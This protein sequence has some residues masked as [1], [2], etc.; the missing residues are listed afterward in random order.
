MPFSFTVVHLDLQNEIH[1][2]HEYN[3]YKG[4]EGYLKFLKKFLEDF[5]YDLQILMD[6]LSNDEITKKLKLMQEE[7]IIFDDPNHSFRLAIYCRTI[8]KSPKLSN[9]LNSADLIPIYKRNFVGA[10]NKNSF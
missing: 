1:K 8:E 6:R 4:E 9:W 2:I 5:K 7:I 10:R 3:G